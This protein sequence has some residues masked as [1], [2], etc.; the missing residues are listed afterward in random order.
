MARPRR[1]VPPYLALIA[2]LPPRAWAAL[3][4][5]FAAGI[6]LDYFGYLPDEL[7][8]VVRQVERDLLGTEIGRPRAPPVGGAQGV[9]LQQARTLLDQIRVEP[10]HRAGYVREDWPHWLRYDGTCLNAREEVLRRQSLRPV[11]LSADGCG[12]VSGFWRDPYT[13]EEFTDPHRLDVDHM[14]PLEEAHASGGYRW[15]RERRAA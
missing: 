5:V 10:P 13:G 3:A 8:G 7:S 14:V 12:I 4:L 15:S 6:G 1:R 11:R 2:M 9:D